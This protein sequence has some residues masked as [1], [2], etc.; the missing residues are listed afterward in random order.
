[1]VY[2]VVKAQFGLS[3]CSQSLVCYFSAFFGEKWI[4]MRKLRQ[5]YVR[6]RDEKDIMPSGT[7]FMLDVIFLVLHDVLSVM[8]LRPF[9]MSRFLVDV[10]MG[11]ETHLLS[12]VYLETFGQDEELDDVRCIIFISSRIGPS[13]IVTTSRYVVPTGRVKVPAGRYVVP[14]GKDNVTVSAGRSKVIPAGRTILVLVVLCLLR[15]DSI[16]S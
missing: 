9:C 16:V 8:S 7:S 5:D 13:I 4:K 1:M 6:K 12:L 14:T 15:V 10:A 3:S 11:M 2:K